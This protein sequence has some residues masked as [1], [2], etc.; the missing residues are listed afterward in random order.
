MLDPN[1]TKPPATPFWLIAVW[2]S[3]VV[4]DHGPLGTSCSGMLRAVKFAP[5][6]S[7]C[8]VV[9]ASL[10]PATA[11]LAGVGL[12]T[13]HLGSSA[14][15]SNSSFWTQPVT[16]PQL[17]PAVCGSAVFG[18]RLNASNCTV[19]LAEPSCLAKTPTFRPPGRPRYCETEIGAPND[20]NVAP[21]VE[22]QVVI[23]PAV[24]SWTNRTHT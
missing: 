13:S 4:T 2:S 24:A 16:P 10:P 7:P 19:S 3:F 11:R 15:P 5:E 18:T 14:V 1:T 22:V 12:R 9:S 20:V 17:S 21:F 6:M 8:A 23:V